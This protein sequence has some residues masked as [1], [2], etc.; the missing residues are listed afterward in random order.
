MPWPRIQSNLALW[1]HRALATGTGGGFVSMR[2]RNFSTPLNLSTFDGIT[3]R[4]RGDGMRYKL[5]LR[6]DT[7]FFALSYQ[8]SFDT[9]EVGPGR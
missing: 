4:V 2:T 7:D 3:M 6:D 9:V 5:I 1:W 8:A